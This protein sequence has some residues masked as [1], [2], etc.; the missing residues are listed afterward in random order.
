MNQYVRVSL[1]NGIVEILGLPTG[2]EVLIRDEDQSAC[3]EKLSPVHTYR[4][5]RDADGNIVEDDWPAIFCREC[6]EQK[7][8]CAC[9]PSRDAEMVSIS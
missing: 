3:N 9:V 1:Y 8:F 5:Y 2:V 6:M 4:V 7:L